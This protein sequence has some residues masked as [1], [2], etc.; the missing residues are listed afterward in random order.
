MTATLSSTS[1]PSLHSHAQALRVALSP[2]ALQAVQALRPQ[3]TQLV[4]DGRTVWG[5]D[6]LRASWCTV[7]VVGADKLEVVP[8]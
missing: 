8:L 1:R 3:V 7:H 2:A 5:Q 6:R 4:A